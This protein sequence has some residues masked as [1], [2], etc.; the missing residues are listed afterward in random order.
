MDQKVSR[1]RDY[2]RSQPTYEGEIYSSQEHLTVDEALD[3]FIKVAIPKTPIIDEARLRTKHRMIK[4][5]WGGEVG[6][7]RGSVAQISDVLRRNLQH[8]A[9]VAGYDGNHVVVLDD[10][11]CTQVYTSYRG[12]ARAYRVWRTR[13]GLALC[14]GRED[15]ILDVR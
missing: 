11:V 12:I 10:R 6:L 4:E 15:T 14:G 3:V 7:A 1:G 13:N 2:R 5:A 9:T 8:N